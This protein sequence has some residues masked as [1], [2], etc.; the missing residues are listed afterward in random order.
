MYYSLFHKQLFD[1][2][3]DIINL[4]PKN[5]FGVFSTVRRAHKIKSYPIDI[6]GCIGYWDTNF[7]TLNKI[8]LYNNLLRVAYDSVWTDNRNHYFTPIETD[9]ETALE[10]DFMLNP[11]YSINKNSGIIIELNTIFTNTKFGIIIQTTDKTQKATYLPNVFPNISWK[12][13][14]I[15]LKNKANITTNDFELFAYKITQI[16]SKFINILT[17]EIFT[18]SC[19]F[20][21]SRILIDNIKLELKY[22]FIYA[23]KNNILEWNTNDDVRNIATLSEIFKY[24]NLYPDIATKT[25]FKNI[26]QKILNILQNIDQYSSQALSFFGYIYQLFNINK[27]L[28]CNKL[29]KDLPFSENEFEKPEIIIGLNKSGC[30]YNE[31]EYLLTYNS[32]DSI[33]KMNWTIQTLNS[34]NKKPSNKLIIILENK[35]DDILINKKNI[36]TNYLAVAFEALCFVYKSKIKKTLL[37]KIFEVFF[38]LEQR[39]NCYNVLY[40]FLDKTARVDITGHIMNGFVELSLSF[41]KT[42]FYQNLTKR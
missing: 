10:L 22:P 9:P 24:I 35:I 30:I 15:S 6:H 1:N 21:F 34:F 18:Y 36:E 7:N 27:E 33:F 32:N 23:C 37:N 19:I 17:S 11:I 2:E 3:R 20:N 38:E 8:T 14:I 28:F 25:E 31:K 13:M 29:L 42:K 39:K 4:C 41:T 26:K 16:K 5:V 40:T 12:N